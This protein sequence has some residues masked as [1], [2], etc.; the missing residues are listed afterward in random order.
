LSPPC[1]SLSLARM[2]FSLSS[3]A[4]SWC[5]S[6]ISQP[7]VFS[8]FLPVDI[9][10]HMLFLYHLGKMTGLPFLSLCWESREAPP[11]LGWDSEWA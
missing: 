5:L 4:S 1:Y 10:D 6:Q 2:L 8:F 9:M 11:P 3:W 7:L